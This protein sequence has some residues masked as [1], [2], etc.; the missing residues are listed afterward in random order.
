MDSRI[1][2]RIAAKD[3]KQRAREM[4]PAR[5][6]FPPISPSPPMPPV[7]A[8]CGLRPQIVEE[9][10]QGRIVG[11]TDAKP[12]KWPWTVSLQKRSWLNYYH[13]CGGTLL[14]KQWVLSAG[15]CFKPNEKWKAVIGIN[16]FTKQ[17]MY[18]QIRKVAE[19]YVH[20]SYSENNT[21]YDIA[22]LKLNKPIE[23]DY[24]A[25]PACLPLNTTPVESMT[26]CFIAGWGHKKEGRRVVSDILQEAR[27]EQIFTPLC[28]STYWYNG[29]IHISNLCAGYEQGEVDSCQGDSGGPLM[30]RRKG[31]KYYYVIGVTS[32]GQGCARKRRPGVYISIRYFFN[33]IIDKILSVDGEV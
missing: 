5:S 7:Q 9:A 3:Q 10:F 27:V 26:D 2:E 18:T 4:E 24:V 14:N 23:Y 31:E 33:W 20:E 19:I 6:S 11:G 32:W 21:Q 13:T 12:G 22:L 1:R 29:K 8:E 25:W 17:K 15:H 30:C 28:N 16:Q